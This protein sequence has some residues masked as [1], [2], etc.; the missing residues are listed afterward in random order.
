MLPASRCWR[1][2]PN[3]KEVRRLSN[4]SATEVSQAQAPSECMFGLGPRKRGSG[5]ADS[6]REDLAASSTEVKVSVPKSVEPPNSGVEKDYFSKTWATQKNLS[7][8]GQSPKFAGP[9][10]LPRDSTSTTKP[11][12]SAYGYVPRPWDHKRIWRYASEVPPRSQEKFVIASYNILA[13]T[14]ARQQRK[15][16]YGHVPDYLLDWKSRKRKIMFELGLCCP[17]VICLQEVDRFR[18]LQEEL[19][20]EGYAGLYKVRTGG[21]PDGC[22]IFWREKRFKLVQE[23]T[24]EF[25]GLGMRD[26]VAQL[27]VLQSIVSGSVNEGIATESRTAGQG[28]SHCLIV[29]NIHVLYNP[30]RGDI[31]LG[32]CRTFLEQVHKL[33]SL[34]DG[35]PVVIGGDFNSTPSSAVYDFLATSELELS[36]LARSYISGQMKAVTRSAPID[37]RGITSRKSR[38]DT[39]SMASSK[40]SLSSLQ[41]SQN[42]QAV[43]NFKE[44]VNVSLKPECAAE[45]QSY[46]TEFASAATEQLDVCCKDTLDGLTGVSS[47]SSSIQG[48]H[49]CASTINILATEQT[50]DE[51]LSLGLNRMHGRTKEDLGDNS[52]VIS[53]MEVVES[54]LGSQVS[55]EHRSQGLPMEEEASSRNSRVLEGHSDKNDKAVMHVLKREP[56]LESVQGSLS[57]I[58]KETL[59]DTAVLSK[60]PVD[61]LNKKPMEDNANL[62]AS[63]LVCDNLSKVD[64]LCEGKGEIDYDMP[65]SSSGHQIPCDNDCHQ[66][67]AFSRKTGFTKT[68][69][70]ESNIIAG[71]SKEA[72]FF[73]VKEQNRGL[74]LSKLVEQGPSQ[75]KQPSLTSSQHANP[76]STEGSSKEA[77][78]LTALIEKRVDQ[79]SSTHT[80]VASEESSCT[81]EFSNSATLESSVIQKESNLVLSG[82]LDL[83]E[84]DSFTSDCSPVL[85]KIGNNLEE[86]INH[87]SDTLLEHGWDFEKLKTATGNP[88]CT[89]LRHKLHLHSVYPEIQG[90]TGTRDEK[91]EPLITTYHRQF[92]G[93]VDYIWRSDGL[94]PVKVLDTVPVNTLLM[95]RGL[96]TKVWGSDHLALA[97][98]LA[99]TTR[100]AELG[101]NKT[102][103]GT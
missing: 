66:L 29:G 57:N 31:K 39:R 17:D 92:R 58:S 101:S 26:N 18:D 53:P 75:D 27:C 67:T 84:L 94:K 48:K 33:S 103:L 50:I 21:A 15:E 38:D 63:S 80:S 71:L 77:V 61:S 47:H 30:K 14:Y 40:Q 95:N 93:T 100:L 9:H 12:P 3:V 70:A 64:V 82:T 102:E 7:S 23:E 88:D 59:A 13:S 1:S 42:Q 19:A 4:P 74:E 43:A 91:G 97:C 51:E 34:W 46:M 35:A 76:G 45:E 49:G 28:Q 6:E 32:Q 96:P 54:S 98:E 52:R 8:N 37:H 56:L 60:I 62:F 78:Q 83:R 69:T 90:Q 99:F 65:R 24:L 20:V 11:G 86:A 36:G 85:E 72:H 22:A 41:I 2:L 79:C 68:P 5:Q 81:P 16:L 44:R 55:H 25:S 73:N 87:N 10:T 89:V